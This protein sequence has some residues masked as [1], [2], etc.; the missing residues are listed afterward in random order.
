M[1]ALQGFDPCKAC[2]LVES[3]QYPQGNSKPLDVA[4]QPLQYKA[5]GVNN[6][7]RD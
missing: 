1:Q 2:K 5:L 4:L 6:C 3:K 7:Q